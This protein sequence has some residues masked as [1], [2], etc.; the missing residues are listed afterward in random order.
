MY[1]YWNGVHQIIAKLVGD[2]MK[3]KNV[4]YKFVS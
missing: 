1:E 4:N 3:Q 2:I